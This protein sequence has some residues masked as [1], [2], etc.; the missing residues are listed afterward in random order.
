[1][2]SFFDQKSWISTVLQRRDVQ[3]IENV[4]NII[5]QKTLK[6]CSNYFCFDFYLYKYFI[7][8]IYRLLTIVICCHLL[9]YIVSFYYRKVLITI[10]KSKGKAYQVLEFR[11]SMFGIPVKWYKRLL[12]KYIQNMLHLEINVT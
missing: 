12:I 11:N 7:G 4:K 1:M 10:L 9:L 8:F 5:K 6:F 2:H 3:K